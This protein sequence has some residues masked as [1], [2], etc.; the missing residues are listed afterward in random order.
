MPPGEVRQACSKQARF[1]EPPPLTRYERCE[2]QEH[3]QGHE[4][5]WRQRTARHGNILRE[6]VRQVFPPRS[7]LCNYVRH[8]GSK[9]LPLSSCNCRTYQGCVRE[10]EYRDVLADCV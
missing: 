2:S 5:Y 10:A 8:P 3:P 9:L 4:G 1:A 6:D 7:Y